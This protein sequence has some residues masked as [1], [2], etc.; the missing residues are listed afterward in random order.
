MAMVKC[1]FCGETFDREKISCIK[2]NNRRYAHASC[3]KQQ[4]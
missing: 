3:A 4:D 1:F 2:V